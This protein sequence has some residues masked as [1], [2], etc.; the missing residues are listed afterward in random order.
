MHADLAAAIAVELAVRVDLRVAFV[1]AVGGLV[2]LFKAGVFAWNGLLAF[3][4]VAVFFGAWFLI[5]PM[6]AALSARKVRCRSWRSGDHT[7]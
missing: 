4:M 1:F 3:W 6:P 5:M 7:L 2:V